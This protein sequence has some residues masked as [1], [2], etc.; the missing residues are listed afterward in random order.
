VSTEDDSIQEEGVLVLLDNIHSMVDVLLL[1]LLVAVEDS[2]PQHL[3]LPTALVL[4]AAVVLSAAVVLPAVL[5][6]VYFPKLMLLLMLLFDCCQLWNDISCSV[7]QL[8]LAFL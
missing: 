4:P 5:L 6:V 2:K 1:L 3:L 7:W 8:D